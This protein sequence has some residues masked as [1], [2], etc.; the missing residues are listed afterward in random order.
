M[1]NELSELALK[2]KQHYS[3]QLEPLKSAKEGQDRYAQQ[4]TERQLA[5]LQSL[6][7]QL[8]KVQIY[9]KNSSYREA[10]QI[11]QRLESQIAT[12][13][14]SDRALEASI[15]LNGELQLRLQNA[16]QVWYARID[17]MVEEARSTCL[18]AE[19]SGELDPLIIK[20]AKLEMQRPNSTNNIVM[21]RGAEKLRGTV[22]TLKIWMHYLDQRN[23][24]NA[25]AA[26][27]ALKKLERNTSNFPLLTQKEL[28]SKWIKIYEQE[29]PEKLAA[30]ILSEMAAKPDKIDQAIQKI[31]EAINNPKLSQHEYFQSQIIPGLTAYKNGFEALAVEDFETAQAMARFLSDVTRRTLIRPYFTA[32]NKRL[33]NH[34]ISLKIEK[35]TAL[36]IDPEQPI[37]SQVDNVLSK[38]WKDQK[39]L[40]IKEVYKLLPSSGNS[41]H[42]SSRRQIQTAINKYL[43]AQQFEKANDFVTAYL[44]Y[45]DALHNTGPE[46]PLNQLTIDALKRVRESYPD[47]IQQF[48]DSALV[49]EIQKLHNDLRSLNRSNQMRRF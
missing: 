15:E 38:L 2:K 48:D 18:Q 45:R 24:G 34:I 6:I 40:D 35:L 3:E 25:E 41:A 47:K 44:C 5:E 28:S 32:M 27:D 29:N 36:T 26:N 1:L 22:N 17:T 9:T 11:M 33:L 10:L 43:T 49:Q 12:N 31:E 21:E 37:D 7:L 16:H 46:H 23:A 4:R 13:L 20:V 42:Y 14:G 30:N 39:L 8:K 19:T